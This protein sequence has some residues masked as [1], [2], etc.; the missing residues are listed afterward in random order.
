MKKDKTKRVYTGINIQYPISQLI[1]SGE[2]TIETR[3]YPVPK[4]YLGKELLIIETP[5]KSGRF[6]SRIVAIVQFDSCFQYKN[7]KDFYA[8][9]AK[10]GVSSDSPWAWNSEK[11]KWGW[12][13]G[14]VKRL[15]A[16]Q[17]N[18]QPGI[19]FSKNIEI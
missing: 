5:G 14:K 11:P 17:L 8:D 19:V 12:I 9:A 2:K 3:T 16:T 6:K 18:R 13:I 1:L 10:H 7:S 15:P 4:K